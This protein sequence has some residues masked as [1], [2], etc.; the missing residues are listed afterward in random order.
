ALT[1]RTESGVSILLHVGLD[2]VSLN[3]KGFRLLVKEGETVRARQ[4]LIEFDLDTIAQNALSAVCVL[5][6]TEG[7]RQFSF[8]SSARIV[9]AG[10][11]EIL[12]LGSVS[13]ERE[14]KP[15]SGEVIKTEQLTIVNPNGLHARPAAQL[16]NRA[17]QFRS[18]VFVH[19]GKAHAAATSV[20]DL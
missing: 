5:V 10:K 12:R 15:E 17:K 14:S 2:T 8:R 19:K 13:V 20:T 4:P 1:L 16:A 11:D 6:V 9:S 18:R 3:G 7:A